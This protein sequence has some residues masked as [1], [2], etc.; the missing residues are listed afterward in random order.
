M[1]KFNIIVKN[2]AGFNTKKKRKKERER[3]RILNS[4]KLFSDHLPAN[5]LNRLS[6]VIKASLVAQMIKSLLAMQETW[7]P[8]QGRE[9]PLEKEMATHS[10]ILAWRNPW[11]KE[12]GRLQPMG[13]QRVRHDWAT[14]THPHTSCYKD[15][16]GDNLP[17]YNSKEM[18]L[19]DLSQVVQVVN[20]GERIFLK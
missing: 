15:K 3:E 4:S 2:K 17:P 19:R 5:C 13:S 12:P 1:P 14:K 6:V 7:V 8:S 16:L 20:D 18:V 9:D 10:S 11:T